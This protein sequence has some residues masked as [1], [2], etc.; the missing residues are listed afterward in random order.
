MPCVS[1]RLLLL[2][3]RMPHLR[4][5][6]PIAG[7]RPG[8]LPHGT[9]P[10]SHFGA[11]EASSKQHVAFVKAVRTLHDFPVGLSADPPSLIDPC[12]R[13]DSSSNLIRR[14]PLSRLRRAARAFAIVVPRLSRDPPSRSRARHISRIPGLPSTASKCAQ[15]STSASA[16]HQVRL[17]R[18]REGLILRWTR[19]ELWAVGYYL[20]ANVVDPFPI[21]AA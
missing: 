18:P 6:T 20:D 10:S 3:C 11:L 14:R 16:T 12:V 19:T 1:N 7:I 2:L 9:D 13:R 5:M 8:S 21:I 4:V 15:R 17:S